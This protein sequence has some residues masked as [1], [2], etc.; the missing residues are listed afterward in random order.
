MG[1]AAFAESTT[2][3]SPG[4][5]LVCHTSCH[6]ELDYRVFTQVA[7]LELWAVLGSNQW[8]LPCEWRALTPSSSEAGLSMAG[9]EWRVVYACE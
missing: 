4:K 6:T 5:F 8:P 7:D 2:G 9:Y 1:M 3:V